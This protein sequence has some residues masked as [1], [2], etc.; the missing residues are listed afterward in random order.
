MV[1]TVSPSFADLLARGVDR[2]PLETE[3]GI[4]FFYQGE[5][6]SVEVLIME[7]R[8]PPAGKM[9]QHADGE[10]WYLETP[11][12]RDGSIEYKLAVTRHEARHVMLDP[13]N[14]EHSNAPFGSNSVANGPDYRA[15]DWLGHAGLPGTVRPFPVESKVWARMKSHLLYLPHSYEPT[16]TLPLL[17]LH[18]GPEYVQYAGLTECLDWLIAS[19][20]IEPTMVLLHRPHARNAEYVGNPR[21]ADHLLNEVIPRLRARHQIG[22]VLAGGASLGAVASLF[23]AYRNPG[24]LDGVMLQSGSFV[25]ELGGPFKRG[26]VLKPVIE[27]LPE[28]LARPIGLP[29]RLVMSCGTYDGLV[30]D[31]R[32]LIPRLL[33]VHPDVTYEEIN[34]GHH[35][36]CWRDRLEPDLMA[37]FRS[38]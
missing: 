6:E 24:T 20:R 14:P 2:G 8:F 32:E 29:P 27:A 12:D 5:A 31:H 9:Q 3:S 7:D 36:R 13:A 16:S 25:S 1:S 35:W 22:R 26:P 4:A 30:E 33:E 38:A 11:L 17:I 21:H 23:V 15:P 37:L 10:T 28:V 19:G 34:S 18:D